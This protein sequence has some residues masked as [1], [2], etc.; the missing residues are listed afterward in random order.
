[1]SRHPLAS[2]FA[3]AYG[4]S[5]L[6]WAPLW[7]P[8][9][10]VEGLPVLPFH[11][12]L[13]AAGPIAAA[14]LVS[15][16]ETGRAGPRDL[17]HRMILWRGRLRWVAVALFGPF[18]LLALAL[19]GAFLMGTENVSLSGVGISREFPQFTA[20]G[21]LIYNIVSFGYGEEVGWRGFALPRLQS[22]HSALGATLLLTVGWAFWHTPLFLYRPGYVSMNAAGIA[23]WFFSLLTGAILLTW[24]YNE[25]KGSLLVVAL[26]HATVDVAFTSDLST[27]ALVNSAGVLITIWGLVILVLVG[28]RY[29]ARHGKMVMFEGDAVTEF[30]YHEGSGTLTTS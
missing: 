12:A 20:V 27:Q 17:L 19:A 5:W 28:P 4:I 8:A 16:Q 9:F 30:L 11:H 6:L 1:M 26:F 14:F 3:I 22:R 18:V 10:G 13:G 7:L 29:L 2:F 25:S 15:A 23:G 24:L 21:F